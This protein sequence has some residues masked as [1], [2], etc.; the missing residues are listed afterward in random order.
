[1]AKSPR[2]GYKAVQSRAMR[3]VL[4]TYEPFIRLGGFASVL[5][6][7]A[8]WEFIVPRRKQAIG[9]LWRWPNNLGV[10][11][12]NTA[13]I[14][15]LFPTTAVGLAILNEARGFGLFNI[16]ALPGWIAITASVVILDL[17]IYLQHVLFHAVPVLWR[18]PPLVPALASFLLYSRLPLH[19]LPL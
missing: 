13:L 7:M 16:I 12:V 8:V 11:I 19:P 10:V 9:R 3:N 18:L 4:F 2:G 1:M 15:I 5:I 14:R 17:A 6:I